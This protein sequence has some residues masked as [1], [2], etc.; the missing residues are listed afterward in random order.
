[1]AWAVVYYQVEGV[2]EIPV[3]QIIAAALRFFY[4][5]KF[6]HYSFIF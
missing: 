1:M 6:T 2:R 3:F 5:L 4:A